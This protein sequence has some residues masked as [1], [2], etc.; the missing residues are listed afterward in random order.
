M[1]MGTTAIEAKTGRDYIRTAKA[2]GLAHFESGAVEVL[3]DVVA[4]VRDDGM[5]YVADATGC[6]CSPVEER[7]GQACGHQWA[8]HFATTADGLDRETAA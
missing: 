1:T 8:V 2:D 3:G 7:G 4:L 5:V 6:G